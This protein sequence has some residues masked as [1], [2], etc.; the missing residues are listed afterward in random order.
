MRSLREPQAPHRL[1]GQAGMRRTASPAGRRCTRRSTSATSV[2]VPAR[3]ADD[4]ASPPNSLTNVW[5]PPCSP[6]LPHPPALPGPALPTRLPRPPRPIRTARSLLGKQAMAL[7][8]HGCKLGTLDHDGLTAFDL[9][10]VRLHDWAAL[11]AGARPGYSEL[12]TWGVNSNFVLAHP[13]PE[14]RVQPDK[15]AFFSNNV[16]LTVDHIVFAKYHTVILADGQ[17]Y[18]CG[19]GRCVRKLLLPI[20]RRPPLN[21]TAHSEGLKNAH[22]FV[23]PQ[24]RAAGPR[25]RG[26]AAAAQARA[27]AG[28]PPCHRDCRRRQ[29]HRRR[30]RREPRLHLWHQRRAFSVFHGPR[31][32]EGGP[33]PNNTQNP[34]AFGNPHDSLHSWGATA[35]PRSRCRRRPCHRPTPR[36]LAAL[37]RRQRVSPPCAA[38]RCWAAVRATSTRSCFP[39]RRSMCVARTL[40]SWGCRRRT[41]W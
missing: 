26:D 32:F 40:A 29:P 36:R 41:A 10:D 11:S 1:R 34:W 15:V 28:G 24:W 13:N 3:P 35:R 17:V 18:T 14:D 5:R 23:R 16:R 27:G 38:R 25:D 21:G 7:L 20:A 12:Y 33:S 30:H 8:A 6:S 9:L 4:S 31:P 37:G 19:F 39:R 22:A 2:S